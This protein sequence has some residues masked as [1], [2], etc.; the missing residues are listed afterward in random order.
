MI[1][2]PLYH[3]SDLQQLN[4]KV[5]FD[6][7]QKLII[8]NPEV[9]SLDVKVDIY[10]SWK[11]WVLLESRKFN[12]W[13]S[14]IRAIGGDPTSAGQFAG[15]IYFM[16]NGWR[17]KRNAA[18]GLTGALFSDDFNSPSID[19]QGNPIALSVVSSLVTAVKVN[20]QDLVDVG[21]PTAIQTAD[22]V[23]D[24]II[25]EHTNAGS[26]GAAQVVNV[27]T[28]PTTAQIADAVW[29]E[30]LSTHTAAGSAGAAL[31]VAPE[32]A[33]AI[34][35][36][37]LREVISDHASVDGSLAESITIIKGLVQSNF[38]LDNTSYTQDF[39]TAAR[40]RI[41]STGGQVAAATDGASGQ[42]EVATFSISAEPESPGSK[43][44]KI[45]KVSKD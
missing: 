33:A 9:T 34:A 5:Y 15:D 36:A 26:A 44:A 14:A 21:I 37:V 28:A 20:L 45:Y 19:P 6:G 31:A 23:W 35:D 4:H 22:A 13:P 38:V 32:T 25:S 29:D 42:G 11:E 16:I 1:V 39:L 10:S 30:D 18:V 2:V 43:N 12:K 7:E 8:V 27:P 24:E 3:A 17:L 41:F 40:I